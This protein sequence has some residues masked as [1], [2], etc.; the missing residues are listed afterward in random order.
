MFLLP[1]NFKEQEFRKPIPY[2]VSFSLPLCSR[3]IQYGVDWKGLKIE[4]S[5]V[6]SFFRSGQ[7]ELPS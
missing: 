3:S 5:V 6:A 4:I 1:L 7:G 2:K